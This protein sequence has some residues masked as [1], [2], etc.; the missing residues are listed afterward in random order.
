[1]TTGRLGA[2]DLAAT[3]DT[4]VYAVPAGKVASFNVGFCNRGVAAVAV[5]LSISSV[6]TPTDAEYLEY[7]AT[8][9]AG[10]VLER[11]GLMA[12]AGKFIVAQASLASVSVVVWGV[13]E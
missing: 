9:P 6:A 10:G 3:T 13:E 1:M 7:N 12:D 5:R 4:T 2:A 8:I 11:G